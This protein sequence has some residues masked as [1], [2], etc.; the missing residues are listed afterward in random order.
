[1]RN[2]NEVAMTSLPRMKNET[3]PMKCLLSSF[4]TYLAETLAEFLVYPRAMWIRQK[5]ERLVRRL[6]VSTLASRLRIA[7]DFLLLPFSEP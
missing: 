1:M 3:L 6:D 5:D 2:K 7:H 4:Q